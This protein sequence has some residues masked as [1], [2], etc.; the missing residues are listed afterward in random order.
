AGKPL[1]AAIESA[2]HH[3]P[4]AAADRAAHVEKWF[5][6]WSALGWFCRPQKYVLTFH[7]QTESF[8]KA[9]IYE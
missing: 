5:H 2:L 3:S 1:N 6:T 4:I 7:G 8:G 9:K